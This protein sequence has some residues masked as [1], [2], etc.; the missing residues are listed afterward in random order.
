VAS[1]TA[2]ASWCVLRLVVELGLR[3][4]LG[5]ELVRSPEGPH[6]VGRLGAKLGEHL[7]LLLLDVVS[8]ACG[9]HLHRRA[10][11]GLGDEVPQ[12]GK[13]VAGETVLVLGLL[14]VL[15]AD[16]LGHDRVEEGLLDRHVRR[17][18][19]FELGEG[20]LAVGALL[21]LGEGAEQLLDLAMLLGEMVQQFH[22]AC[23]P[24]VARWRSLLPRHP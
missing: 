18:G 10:E 14:L 16:H 11:A 17:Q 4:H 1:V 13:T 21:A 20:G 24:E 8:D 9:D 7:L 2:S 22:G 15:R 3:L 23:P 6:L 19:R 12:L 5:L